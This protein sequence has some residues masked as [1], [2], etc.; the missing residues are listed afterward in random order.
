MQIHQSTFVGSFPSVTNCPKEILPEYAFIGRSNV[1]KSSLINY[2][3]ARKEL[4]LVS[5]RPG[6]TQMINF[7]NIDHQWHLVD[8]P[9]YG[10]AKISQKKRKEWE[11]MIRDYFTKREQLVCAFVLIDSNIPPQKLDLEFINWLG[12]IQLPF[13]I[14]FTKCD[15]SKSLKLEDNINLFK[16]TILEQWTELPTCFVSSAEKKIGGEEI[17]DF[18]EEVN[19]NFY[20]TFKA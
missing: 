4:A 10:Y 6:K 2:L 13:A 17:L 15:K 5:S 11:S 14:I 1:G 20:R 9:G 16:N 12:E 18:I 3:C 8:L 19:Q 7:F